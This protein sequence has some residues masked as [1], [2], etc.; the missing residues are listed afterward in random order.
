MELS[1]IRGIG[2]SRL[3]ALRA[4]GIGS[5]RDLLYR[6]P[7]RYED[8]TRVTP[9]AQLL[10][11]PAM[12][13]G[14]VREAPKINRFG[15]LTRVTAQLQDGTGRLPLVWFNQPWM[16]Q[17]L[18]VGEPVTLYGTMTVRGG[19][20]SFQ[21]A[22]VVTEP[23]ILPVYK[24][25]AGIPARSY[26]TMMRQ[27]LESVDECCPETLPRALRLRHGLCEK[28]YA[29]RQAH[30]PD[31][32]EDLRT[33][34]RRI[35]FEQMLL[36]QAALSDARDAVMPGFPMPIADGAEDRFWASMHFP[37][38]VAQ[39]RVLGEI[40]TDLKRDRAM[41][42]LVQGDVGCGKTALAFG[43]IALSCGC[44]YQCAMMAPTEILAR[45]HY[46]TACRLLEPMGIRCGL[47]TGSMKP[48]ERRQAHQAAAD[49]TWQAVFGTHAL[50]SE[51]V[52]Y[53]RL[54][55]VITDEQHRFGVRQRSV[56]RD[57]GEQEGRV[58]HVLVMS[59]TPIPRTLALILYGD[60]DL[61]VVDE[62][63]PGRTPVRTRLVPENRR[64]DM[65]AFV[66]REIAAGRQAYVVCPLVEDSE[67]LG[68]VRA[69]QTTW[70]ELCEGPLKGIRVGLT[71]G[72]QPPHEK[73][74]VLHA[75]A[76]GE[77][78]VLVSTTVIEVGVNVPNASVMIVENAERFGLSQLHQLRGRVGRGSAE[79]WCFLLADD[80][81]KLHILTAT[82]DGF[83]VARKD[84]ELRGPGDL[85]GTRQSGEAFA[86]I[87]LDGD[88]RLLDETAACL[89]D[90]RKDPALAGELEAVRASAR[91]A[92]R[93][94]IREIARN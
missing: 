19:R 48:S 5:L 73:E 57:R 22:S 26:R 4:V 53:A 18:P 39:R 45:Q 12:V 10:P 91:E 67:T 65:Y 31:S 9:V 55:L 13:S 42:R 88:V 51:G 36:F 27:A 80:T 81:E 87:L 72:D 17:Q 56:L 86:D 29:I 60:L 76:S 61:S 44:G 83:E 35:G 50:I 89:R 52:A 38:T 46:E 92:M 8:R 33:A 79:S 69:A 77:M 1:A 37:P 94:R 93:G 14:V 23:C 28:N 71:W 47:M 59:A 82:S 43:A 63:P 68:D 64:E 49:G 54:G 21:N 75:F 70:R 24:A 3:E 66:R 41:S 32:A 34:R 85:M 40:A 90:L 7:V 74:E 62:L 6:L 2:P 58:P 20:R 15:G 78:D 30:F 16:M 25:V 11:G 84:L